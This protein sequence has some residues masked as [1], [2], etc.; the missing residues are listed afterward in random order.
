MEFVIDN[1]KSLIDIIN[2]YLESERGA[3]FWRGSCI[4]MG[5]S[6]SITFIFSILNY[7]EKRKMQISR[8]RLL[9][10]L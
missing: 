6:A 8:E 10:R 7:L 4:S 5:I 9:E 1:M 3:D 2:H